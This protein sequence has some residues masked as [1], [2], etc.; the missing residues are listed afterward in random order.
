MMPDSKSVQKNLSRIASKELVLAAARIMGFKMGKPEYGSAG[1]ISG[2]RT[3]SL[4]YSQRH[5]SRTIFATDSGYAHNAKGGPWSGADRVAISACRKVMQSARIPMKEIAA[6]EVVTE[7][8]QVAQLLSANESRVQEPKL[9]RKF[10]RA[11][12]A[13][14][15]IPVWSSYSCVG[16]NRKGAAGWLELHWPELPSAVTAEATLLQQLVKRGV[17]APRLERAKVESMEA[18][19]LHSPAIA[20]FMDVVPAIRVVYANDEPPIGRKPV[21]YLDR[22]G[23]WV[24]LPRDINLANAPPTGRPKPQEK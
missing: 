13:V 10:A 4:T 7:M 19:I 9:L 16:L 18:G 22:H 8:G 23:E 11:R 24:T 2:V 6:I 14:K 17:E 15:G 1:N 20:F 12:R 5:D 3:K 21:L